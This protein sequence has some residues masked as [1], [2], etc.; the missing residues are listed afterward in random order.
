MTFKESL[1]H[2][3]NIYLKEALAESMTTCNSNIL[4][5]QKQPFVVSGVEPKSQANHLDILIK[6]LL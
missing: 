2:T 5:T 1:K 3:Y 4:E 6:L